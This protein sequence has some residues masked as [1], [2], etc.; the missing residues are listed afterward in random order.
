LLAADGMRP[1][2]PDSV[3]VGRERVHNLPIFTVSVC[4]RRDYVFPLGVVM[5][6]MPMAIH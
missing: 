2:P 5:A 4:R 6:A 1:P 3:S